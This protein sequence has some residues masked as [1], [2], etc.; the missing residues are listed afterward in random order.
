M[1]SLPLFRSTLPTTF[2]HAL[3]TP[4]IHSQQQRGPRHRGL[5]LHPDV[6]Q[7]ASLPW[8]PCQHTFPPTEPAR[9]GVTWAQQSETIIWLLPFWHVSWRTSAVCS[10]IPRIFK[11]HFNDVLVFTA[12]NVFRARRFLA[13]ISSAVFCWRRGLWQTSS[14]SCH[15]FAIATGKLLLLA[16]ALGSLSHWCRCSNCHG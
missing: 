4:C 11:V 9:P 10:K 13:F 2:P 15:C 5:P 6:E 16:A 7:K 3:Q 1:S 12:Q 8:H 14:H